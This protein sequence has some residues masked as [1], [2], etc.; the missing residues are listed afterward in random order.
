MTQ[1]TDFS[2]QNNILRKISLTGDIFLIGEFSMLRDITNKKLVLDIEP[3]Q[4]N[5]RNSE[6]SF[7]RLKD[8]TIMFAYSRYSSA[9]AHDHAN[10]DIAAIYSQDE[11]E[12]WSEPSIIVKAEAFGVS[13]IMSVSLIYQQDGKVGAYFIVKNSNETNSLGRALSED[14]KNFEPELCVLDTFKAYFVFNNDRLIRLR[15]SRLCLPVA[16]H[17]FQPIGSHAITLCLMSEDDGKTFA[18]TDVRL[19]ISATKHRD[20]GM[21]E[22]GVYEHKD[23]T[24]RIWART[25]R[26][27]QYESYSRDGFKTCNDPAPSIFTSPCSPMEFA[28][29]ENTDTLY[30]AYNPVP[31]YLSASNHYEGNS[32]GRTPLVIRKSTDDGRSWGDLN[33]VEKDKDRGYCYPAMFFTKDGCML[34]AYCRGGEKDENCLARLG[35]S[36]INLDDIL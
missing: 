17:T 5:G 32:M 10:C 16:A 33:V 27:F 3:T 21:Q 35:I 9:S 4:T 15:D 24:M 6:G 11:G 13:N 14:G 19:T 18:P 20:Y 30:A 22:P 25:T 1:A 12:T 26:G 34:I 29:D 2:V 28:L 8:G 31:N 23:G 36:K 7:L